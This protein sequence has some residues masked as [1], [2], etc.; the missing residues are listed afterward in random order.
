MSDY[1]SYLLFFVFAAVAHCFALRSF[2]RAS[3]RQDNSW[4]PN[5][6]LLWTI[7]TVSNLILFDIALLAALAIMSVQAW[8]ELLPAPKDAKDVNWHASLFESVMYVT[9]VT[10]VVMWF[11]FLALMILAFWKRGR[12]GSVENFDT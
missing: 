12:P 5:K 11:S 1:V 4:S 9:P 8:G 7:A 3:G 6:K 10:I 2:R